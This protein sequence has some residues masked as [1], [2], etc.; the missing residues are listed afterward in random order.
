MPHHGGGVES[1]EGDNGGGDG[2][3]REIETSIEW[4]E[5]KSKTENEEGTDKLTSG[6]GRGS[7]YVA[8]TCEL[9][10]KPGSR[11]FFLGTVEE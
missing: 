9:C 7:R 6:G 10:G 4:K 3:T 1:G 8:Q 11:K 5:E 2:L